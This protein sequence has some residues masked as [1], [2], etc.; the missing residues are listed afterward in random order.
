VRL[1]KDAVR[2]NAA[3]RGIANLCLNSIWGKLTERCDRAKTRM[4]S[5]PHELHRFLATPGNEVTSLTFVS[6]EV[7][8]AAWRY[9]DDKIVPNLRHTNEVIGA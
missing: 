4:I 7:V 9:S 5:D 1:D 8:W 3:E 6:D 2:P